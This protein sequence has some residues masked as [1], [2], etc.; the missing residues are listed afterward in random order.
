[1]ATKAGSVGGAFTPEDYCSS[2]A[3]S[4]PGCRAT[5]S[6]YLGASGPSSNDL[7]W[8]ARFFQK[9]AMEPGADARWSPHYYCGT[10][11]EALKFNTDQWYEL[12]G[13]ANE[14][15]KLITDQW[16][17][18]GKFDP[19]HNIRLVIDEWGDWHKPGSEINPRHLYEQ[20]SCL[21]DALVA[22]LTLDTFNR[23]A[24]K[25]AW[26]NVAQLVN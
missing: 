20:T 10:A 21:R 24:E 19:Q 16:A 12:L 15:E 9:L 13:R 8:T 3:S 6:A 7:N 22:A 23:H 26:A 25:V 1:V 14:M 17:V 4:P 18:M 5:A 2:T 11:G